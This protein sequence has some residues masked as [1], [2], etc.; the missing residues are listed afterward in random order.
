MLRRLARYL[1]VAAVR[2]T[3]LFR[4]RITVL[5]WQ[6][7]HERAADRQQELSAT[8]G[9]QY[10]DQSRERGLRGARGALVVV[11]EPSERAE[12]AAADVFALL[13]SQ[14][15][16]GSALVPVQ[17]GTK[18]PD[19]ERRRALAASVPGTAFRLADVRAALEQIGDG[20]TALEL[21]VWAAARSARP[22]R[23]I[24]CDDVNRTMSVAGTEDALSAAEALACAARDAVVVR[25]GDR[26]REEVTRL[27]ALRVGQALKADP[28][29]PATIDA[30]YGG[31]DERV[32]SRADIN[33]AAAT[34]LAVVYA[35][36]PYLDSGGFVAARRLA[37]AGAPYDV[38]TKEVASERPTDQR[39]LELT[40]GLLGQH[41]TVQGRT[42]FGSWRA[43]EHFCQ[44]GMALV[45]RRERSLGRYE[46][47]YTR[48]MWPAPGAFGALYKAR[49]PAARWI[50]EIS[51]P[52]RVRTDGTEREYALPQ[53]PIVIEVLDALR[54][55]G[56]ENTSGLGVFEFLELATYALADEI[57]FTNEGQRD[58]MLETFPHEGAAARARAISR[59]SHHPT[60]DPH[61]Y[62]L[63]DPTPGLQ[64]GRVRVGYF[65]RFYG[66]RSV[67]D[68][69]APFAA[70]TPDERERV[71]LS[72]FTTD[73]DDVRATLAEH[74]LSALADVREALPYFDFLSTAKAMDWL[75]LADARTQG[76]FAVNP[77][78]PS[79]LAD[80]LGSGTRI[81][82]LVE[83]GSALSRARL[84][85]S[86]PLGDVESA[87]KVL[88]TRLLGAP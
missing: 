59:V 67:V 27:A 54:G 69:V 57:V 20:A 42:G 30:A 13:A 82:G 37:L 83:A 50:A 11:L 31:H 76:T 71:A 3:S 40:Q 22:I 70:L 23:L 85:A 41:M 87:V 63:A 15:Y 77:Y 6:P 66:V 10:L 16:R 24:E 79:K 8:P 68:L 55:S 35:F 64:E 7:P 38:L 84:A 48:A 33:A 5:T 44:Q 25:G 65:G 18:S 81:W 12:L 62:E 47:I 9:V 43:I 75:M 49:H 80:Y 78:L 1:D 4:P 56:F 2:A 29:G 88:R 73:H 52:L 21:R 26:F 58:V 86:S 17:P 51:D 72:I 14:R 61:S 32:L 36:P 34:K 28:A 46:S 53:S 60:P 45:E 19:W 39:S 74:G